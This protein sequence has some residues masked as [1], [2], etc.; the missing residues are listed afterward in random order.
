[1]KNRVQNFEEF[2][3]CLQREYLVAELRYQIY[4]KEKDKNYYLHKEMEGKR[5]T[6]ESIS[7]RNNFP[8][9]F[10]DSWLKERY[11]SEI[12]NEWGLPNFVYRSDE[13]RQ[14]RRPKDIIAYF[15]KGVPV[16][17]KTDRGVLPGTI[18]W[19]DLEQNTA[20]VEIDGK[21]QTLP[22]DNLKRIL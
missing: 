5:S 21:Q 16:Q 19:T 14:N 1:M 9:I 12:Y 8:S 17:V 6:I 7:A 2:Y 3:A 15:H 18:I 13:D 10:T 22:F 20:V 4:V 11:K